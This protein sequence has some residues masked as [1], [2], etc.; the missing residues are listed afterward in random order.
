MRPLILALVLLIF[1]ACTSDSRDL[2]HG[3]SVKTKSY[4]VVG[5]F[6]S[7]MHHKY[8]YF[9]GEE[10][11]QVGQHSISPSGRFLIF[12]EVGRLMLFDAKSKSLKDVTDGKFALPRD[13][14]W[15]ETEKLAI[16]SY[17]EGKDELHKPSTI[18]LPD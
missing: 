4:P 9:K 14:N 16:V 13:V 1:Q 17:Y 8:I 11:G 18:N 12:E 2:G 15:K 6:E 10:I 7:L 5:G 3:Y